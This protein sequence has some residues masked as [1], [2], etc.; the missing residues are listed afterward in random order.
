LLQV[1]VALLVT[2]KV[3][4]ASG[5][6]AAHALRRMVVSSPW[7]MSPSEQVTLCAAML[8]PVFDAGRAQQ[9][10]ITLAYVDLKL[11]QQHRHS[12]TT[13]RLNY[14]CTRGNAVFSGQRRKLATCHEPTKATISEP[15]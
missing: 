1:A 12:A 9:K 15:R 4:T 14:H 8:Q 13:A 5:S 10:A 7:F 2:F 11:I 6:V 3:A